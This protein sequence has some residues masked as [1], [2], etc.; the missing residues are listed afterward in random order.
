MHQKYQ[1]WLEDGWNQSKTV[2]K[3]HQSYSLWINSEHE[4]KV[5][6]VQNEVIWSCWF[7]LQHTI[8]L[9]RF[10]TWSK[11]SVCWV[12]I[13]GEKADMVAHGTQQSWKPPGPTPTLCFHILYSKIPPQ[14][15]HWTVKPNSLTV[16]TTHFHRILLH[17]LFQ[18]STL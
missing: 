2:P 14:S 15:H 1:R 8:H 13:R 11:M 10:K 16:T 5:G 3:Y 18:H 6:S 12:I 4:P 7:Y 9:S 17:F